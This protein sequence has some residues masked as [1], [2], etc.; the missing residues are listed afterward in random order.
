[1]VERDVVALTDAQNELIVAR[2]GHARL[3]HFDR[4][5][6]PW[7]ASRLKRLGAGVEHFHGNL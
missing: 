6:K 2:L 5:V 7:A 3:R 4:I 1:M